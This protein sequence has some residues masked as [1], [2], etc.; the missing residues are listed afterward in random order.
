[1]GGGAVR[2]E[3]PLELAS[4]ELWRALGCMAPLSYGLCRCESSRAHLKL[5]AFWFGYELR[6][7][8]CETESN[9]RYKVSGTHRQA[10]PLLMRHV[11]P[12]GPLPFPP[13]P[14]MYTGTEPPTS[15]CLIPDVELVCMHD[16]VD[17]V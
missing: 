10:S 15:P 7:E 17:R 1:M 4:L 11:P 6:M 3:F 14:E 9:F 13:L 16:I 12:I 2:V 8:N 5:C